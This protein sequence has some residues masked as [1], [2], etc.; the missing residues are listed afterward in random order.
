MSITSEQTKK[1]VVGFIGLG[2]IGGPMATVM[3]SEFPTIGHDLARRDAVGLRN[4]KLVADIEAIARGSDIICLSLPDGEAC[5]DVVRTIASIHPIRAKVIVELSTIGIAMV[6]RCAEIAQSANLEYVDAPVS[7]GAARAATG[8]LAIMAAGSRDALARARPVLTQISSRLFIMG[9]QPGLGQVMKLANNIIVAASMAITSEAIVF[10][11]RFGLTLDHM[12][13]VINASTGRTE[14]SEMKFPRA[15]V[16]RTFNLGGRIDTLRKDVR[17]YTSEAELAGM[18]FFVA[19]SIAD[20]WETLYKE[21]PKGDFSLVYKY[22]E[23][24]A[25]EALRHR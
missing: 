25:D 20:L 14:A 2:Q 6:K 5:L 17:L 13:D 22:I 4:V 16:P 18:P 11:T 9:E 21:N 24:I 12:V 10:G 1:T 3:S 7:G 8:D 19:D 23:D 15:I